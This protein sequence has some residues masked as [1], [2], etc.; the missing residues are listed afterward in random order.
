MNEYFEIK[1][2]TFIG[3]KKKAVPKKKQVKET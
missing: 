1:N 3:G 2:F